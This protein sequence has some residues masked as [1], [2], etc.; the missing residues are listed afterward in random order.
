[1]P[2]NNNFPIAGSLLPDIYKSITESVTFMD[3]LNIETKFSNAYAKTVNYFQYKN[4]APNTSRVSRGVNSFE[5]VNNKV[6]SHAFQV[7]AHALSANVALSDYKALLN[8]AGNLSPTNADLLAEA[9]ETTM[10]QLMLNI[11]AEMF[12]GVGKTVCGGLFAPASGETVATESAPVLGATDWA[13]VDPHAIYNYFNGL[14]AEIASANGLAYGPKDLVIPVAYQGAFQ[15]ASQF[16]GT[17]FGTPEGLLE[18]NGFSITYMARS[19]KNKAG[20]L[21]DRILLY[22][23][24]STFGYIVSLPIQHTY[25]LEVESKADALYVPFWAAHGGV[26]FRRPFLARYIPLPVVS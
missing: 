2:I 17:S 19:V 3:A 7:Q 8:N 4:V 15:A 25:E 11:D 9:I 12:H 1:M 24:E 10:K 5:V 16:T 6:F 23:K 22:E 21:E 13:G 20:V 18:Q 26:N 14:S